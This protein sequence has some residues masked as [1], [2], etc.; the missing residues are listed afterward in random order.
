AS[1]GRRDLHRLPQRRG[2][3][4]QLRGERPHRRHAGPRADRHR[5]QDRRT[6]RSR[7]VQATWF[8]SLRLLLSCGAA[9]G[10]LYAGA[11][12]RALRELAP[13]ADIAGLGGPELDRAGGRVLVDYRGLSVTGFTEIVSKVPRLR[14]A[15]RTLMDEARNSKPHALVA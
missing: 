8:L 15:K 2:C 4:D 9:S 10:D 12:T 7:P 11:L 14:A 5:Y 3:A 13:D 1:A 6:A